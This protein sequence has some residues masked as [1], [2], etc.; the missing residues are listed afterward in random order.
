MGI[1]KNIVKK[2]KNF[3]YPLNIYFFTI[4][5]I[6]ITFLI[7]FFPI[8]KNRK[9]ESIYSNENIQTLT[10]NRITTTNET[11][12]MSPFLVDF[13]IDKEN[14]S[15]EIFSRSN[16]AE[17][18][19]KK[20]T[21]SKRIYL[22]NDT[23]LNVLSEL[24]KLTDIKPIIY[25]YNDSN[26]IV[27][28]DGYEKNLSL[29]KD[30]VHSSFLKSG[31]YK[32][33]FIIRTDLVNKILINTTSSLIKEEI[34]YETYVLNNLKKINIDFLPGQQKRLEEII[35]YRDS[36]YSNETNWLERNLIV[37]KES[38]QGYITNNGN[39]SLVE[40]TL[41]GRNEAHKSENNFTSINV[42]IKNGPL[43]Y[44]LKR[45]KLYLLKS[46]SYGLDF[47]LESFY[48]DLDSIFYLQDLVDLSI[49]GS[50]YGLVLLHHQIEEYFFEYNKIQESY[51]LNY[52]MDSLIANNGNS[53]FKV[54]ENYLNTKPDSSLSSYEFLENLCVQETSKLLGFATIYFGQHGLSADTR[55]YKNKI[56][57]C[58]EPIYKDMNAGVGSIE[59]N[60]NNL[61]GNLGNLIR[62]SS[63]FTPNWRPTMPTFNSFF[64]KKNN[65]IITVPEQN[66]YW[67]TVTP[68]FTN[69]M[70]NKDLQKNTLIWLNFLS[71]QNIVDSV[72]NRLDNYI[73]Q[74]DK[75][76]KNISDVNKY[77]NLKDANLVSPIKNI[78]TNNN[79]CDIGFEKN[80][81]VLTNNEVSIDCSITNNKIKRNKLI[82]E[83]VK[84]NEVKK[85]IPLLNLT[86]ETII[87]Y[88]YQDIVDQN[89]HHLFFVGL[90]CDSICAD[91][92][93]LKDK[94]SDTK[95]EP[96]KILINDRANK[97]TYLDLILGEYKE[98]ENMTLFW[99][100]V[101]KTTSHQNLE[102]M[103]L[104]N[105][106][107]Y[108]SKGLT[109]LPLSR[110]ENNYSENL[111][112]KYFNIDGYE[113]TFKNSLNS[114]ED[115]LY[116]PKEYYL[117][118]DK[119]TELLFKKEA[120]L[121]IEGK[122][123]SNYSLKLKGQ[124]W[125][126]LHFIN[127]E[128]VLR[129][130]N[131]EISGVGKN[132]YGITCLGRSL[133][134]GLTIK[135]SYIDIKNLRI[136]DSKTE[137]TLHVFRSFGS[138]ENVLI[139]NSF[140]DGIDIDFSEVTI[141]NL[142]IRNI[143]SGEDLGDCLD[144]SNSNITINNSEFSFCTD[145]SLSIG[146]NSVVY[147]KESIVS[148]SDI[149][150]AIKDNSSFTYKNITVSDNNKGISIYSKKQSYKKPNFSELF[151]DD[152]K[153]KDNKENLDN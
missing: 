49:N 30:L 27:S 102:P 25:I 98:N 137:D 28:K 89:F 146:E 97:K 41:A 53:I 54:E 85:N 106:F 10:T 75:N 14:Y 56:H 91:N 66:F 40:I 39:Q 11:F 129:I 142:I 23:Q 100:K 65:Q 69:S 48:S 37:P 147:M 7:V 151:F 136:S 71:S 132:E 18:I 61:E 44:G 122:F 12:L 112:D 63:V 152:V 125:N 116:I 32:I 59:L 124:N 104:G 139:N 130:N 15:F 73:A 115:Q 17:E 131:L 19:P 24:S 78:L 5:I 36:I 84:N 150:I 82:Y 77:K 86:S 51:V 29:N 138:L 149:G 143:G 3:I 111:L 80:I 35:E 141:S 38:V 52:D 128:N 99:F 58:W 64:V 140:S 107:Y 109:V 94:L 13:V 127:L 68:P 103:Y 126:G 79:T 81:E 92:F 110:N 70:L 134:G 6:F 88:F 101:A 55:F 83:F 108:G 50:N 8:A 144:V 135:D 90:N 72:S 113:L 46:K 119:D 153:F 118:I 16:T 145:K 62:L 133:L 22:S 9:L 96:L 43:I 26:Q 148:N 42:E 57:G 67:W 45:F 34:T 4:F 117:K 60:S 2:F 74:L 31:L 114:I 123:S 120:C 121:L 87:T 105:G 21:L 33:E 1:L 20:I 93:S 76:L 47:V 95:I